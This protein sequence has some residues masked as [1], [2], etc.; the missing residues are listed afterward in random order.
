MGVLLL[1]CHWELE[2][3]RVTVLWELEDGRRGAS[4]VMEA[5]IWIVS[6]VWLRHGELKERRGIVLWVFYG[7]VMVTR[8][9]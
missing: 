1:V 6:G 5:W 8:R 7:C 4:S 3:W 2:D 9:P